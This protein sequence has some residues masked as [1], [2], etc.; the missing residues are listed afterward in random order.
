M[1]ESLLNI[2]CKQEPPLEMFLSDHDKNFADEY[3][4][5]AKINDQDIVVGFHPGC[6]TLKNHIKRRWEPEKFAALGSA[7]IKNYRAKILL[8]GGPDENDLKEDILR[9][10]DS[11]D[12]IFVQNNTIP[13]NAAVMSRCN[14]FVTNDSSQMHVAAALQLKTVAIIGP[15]NMNYIY[16]WKA[17]HKIVSLNLDCSP[18]FFYSPKP[19][20]CNRDDVQFK[21]IKELTVDM[22]YDAVKSFL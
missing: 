3:L 5:N 19:L 1:C 4:K 12:A 14:L 2:R 6:S 18:C 8:F 9:K 21:C 17:N 10:I 7:L 20:V 22:V 11:P 15:T 13:E 16:P